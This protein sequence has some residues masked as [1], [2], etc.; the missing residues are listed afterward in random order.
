MGRSPCYHPSYNQ[1][2]Y[3][4]TLQKLD[5]GYMGCRL[6]TARV[7]KEGGPFPCQYP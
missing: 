3:Y 2:E 4:K 7:P 5:A 1:S 6:G